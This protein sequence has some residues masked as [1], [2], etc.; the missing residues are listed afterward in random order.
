TLA[1]TLTNQE[2]ADLVTAI[3]T[4]AGEGINLAGLRYG[5]IILLMD[6]DVDGH[7]I[8]TL[9]LTFFF[10]HLTELIRKGH[11]YIAQPPLYRI[12][13]G[14]ETYWGRD[15]AHREQILAGL[16]AGAKPVI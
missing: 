15:D 4:G 10:R 12:N 9:L 1:N 2:L 14:K 13:V 7:H 16:R 6:A 8:T 5:K 3:G 11:L